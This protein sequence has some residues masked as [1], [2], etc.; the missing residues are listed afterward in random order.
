MMHFYQE[1][2]MFA[3]CFSVSMLLMALM[4]YSAIKKPQIPFV[5]PVYF[6]SKVGAVFSIVATIGFI[7][8]N[9]VEVNQSC[10]WLI[11]SVANVFVFGCVLS[12]NLNYE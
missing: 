11:L 3:I 7:C 12:K 5:D 1:Y 10:G 9:V 6:F 8:T 4:I 2:K